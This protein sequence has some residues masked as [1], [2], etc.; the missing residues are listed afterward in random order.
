VVAAAVAAIAG[1]DADAANTAAIAQ[2]AS[3]LMIPSLKES[4]SVDQ[5]R[6]VVPA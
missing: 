1:T 4:R 2:I 6:E 5:P 3:D